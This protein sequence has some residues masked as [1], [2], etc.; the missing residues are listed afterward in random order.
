MKNTIVKTALLATTLLASNA[1]A[2]D[3]VVV[4]VADKEVKASELNEILKS[5]PP[6]VREKKGPEVE[7]MMRDR[8]TDMLVLV[9]AAQDAKIQDRDDVKKAITAATEQVITQAYVGDLVKAKATDAEIK[10]RYE[11]ALKKF[12]SQEE[13][14]AAHILVKDEAEAKKIHEEVTKDASKFAKIA[15]DKSVDKGSGEKGGD[16]GFVRQGMVVEPFWAALNGLKK[17][18]ISEPF[19]T[20]FGWHIAKR[21]ESRKVTPPTLEETKDELKNAIAA[22]TVAEKAKELRSQYKV[23][24]F[25]TDGKPYEAPK[26]PEAKDEAGSK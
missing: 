11:Q 8:L 24:Q 17:G 14:K 5:L 3:E 7:A 6:Q 20:D 21:E 4:R 1:F 10:K 22:E 26:A 9:K 2:K 16:L 19:K 25:T 23:E 13:V 18:G 12:G 15:K